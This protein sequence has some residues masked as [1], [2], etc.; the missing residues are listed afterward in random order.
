MNFDLQLHTISHVTYLEDNVVSEGVFDAP[1]HI[2]SLTLCQLHRFV[3][4]L[5]QWANA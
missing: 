4:G 2:L 5:E 1:D 3:R